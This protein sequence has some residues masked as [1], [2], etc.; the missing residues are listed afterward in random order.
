MLLVPGFLPGV[1]PFHVIP[2]IPGPA[3]PSDPWDWSSTGCITTS[4]TRW[5]SARC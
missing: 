2:H 1:V 4:A 5:L 3:I